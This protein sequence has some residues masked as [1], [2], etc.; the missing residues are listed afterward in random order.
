LVEDLFFN[1][2]TRQ[3]AF[4]QPSEEHAKVLE[5]VTRYAIHNG[6]R[7][8]GFTCKKQGSAT[9]DIHCPPCSG[10]SSGTLAAIRIAYGPTLARELLPL[11]CSE[12]ASSSSPT[13]GGETDGNDGGGAT[14]LSSSSSS[15][16]QPGDP[17][18]SGF[19]FTAKGFISNANYSTK[20]AAFLL[21]I[22]D[23]LVESTAIRRCIDAVYKDI[24]P[25]HMQP[26]VYLAL[27]LP[28]K[29][30]DVNVHPTKREV[31]FLN[32]D[33]LLRALHGALQA[34]LR[35][36]NQSRAF[37]CQTINPGDLMLSSS[38]AVHGD[39]RLGVG[40]SKIRAGPVVATGPT[41]DTQP[42]V[43][44]T[45]SEEVSAS[46]GGET[47]QQEVLDIG[48]FSA[49]PSSSSSS[50]SSAG[51]SSGSSG[52]AAAV[53]TVSL[54][55]STDGKNGGCGSSGGAGKRPHRA[56]NKL[57]RADSRTQSL[58]G[59]LVRTPSTPSESSTDDN[60]RPRLASSPEADEGGEGG[61]NGTSSSSSSSSGNGTDGSTATAVSC[62]ICPPGAVDISAVGAFARGSNNC[63]CREVRKPPAEAA[64]A[65]VAA[66]TSAGPASGRKRL[67]PLV[68]TA[69]SYESVQGLIAEIKSNGDRNLTSILKKHVFVGLADQSLTLVQW[70]T[71][72][73]L[74]NHV[75][76]ARELFF[77]IAIR[78]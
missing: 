1:M 48:S 4:K 59:F 53:R 60:K 29:N 37:V 78:R 57:V 52:E 32:E 67:R 23:R 46:G 12:S 75:E 54:D 19:S 18:D 70:D 13:G 77:Q 38:S 33:R 28:P 20:R 10:G 42:E 43:Y 6:D 51:A 2:P 63:N 35:S 69:C 11:T 21:F 58:D 68:D 5:V 73:L 39:S 34:T 7:G 25:N 49:R 62:V 50:S 27:Q 45:A 31:H 36:A 74:V 71:K 55:L 8:V 9:A 22:N 30:V 47:K 72:L 44:D 16:V 76:L 66:V 24:L 15:S 65:A 56:D 61:D 64:A 3:R 14:Y 41:P 40:G 26:F 17:Q